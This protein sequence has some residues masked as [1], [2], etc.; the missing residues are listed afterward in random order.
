M[1]NLKNEEDT[2]TTGCNKRVLPSSIIDEQ[3]PL[4]EDGEMPQKKFY[5]S[6][7]H[8]YVVSLGVI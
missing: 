4:T 3:G 5:R 2:K 7:A 1:S 6:R 8:W